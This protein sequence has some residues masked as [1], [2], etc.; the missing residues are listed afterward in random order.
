MIVDLDVPRGTSLFL[1]AA[2]IDPNPTHRDE[3][4][5]TVAVYRDATAGMV[6]L[7]G[8]TCPRQECRKGWCF[9]ARVSVAAIRANLDGTL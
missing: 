3:L 8:H 7:Q 2:A 5:S 4:V 9:E 1:P 6:L